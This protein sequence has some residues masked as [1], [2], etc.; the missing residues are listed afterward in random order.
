MKASA[1]ALS[2]KT[3][4]VKQQLMETYFDNMM[5]DEGSKEKLARDLWVLANDSKN[6]LVDVGRNAVA[7]VQATDKMIRKHPYASLAGAFG[8]GVVVGWYLCSRRE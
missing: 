4:T 7:E 3:D 1:V 5:A 2:R 6:A 8:L